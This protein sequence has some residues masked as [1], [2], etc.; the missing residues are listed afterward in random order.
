M[1]SCALEKNSNLSPHTRSRSATATTLQSLWVELIGVI[2]ALM[3]GHDGAQ[4]DYRDGVTVYN[5]R[6]RIQDKSI[7]SPLFFFIRQWMSL[8]G[9]WFC[10]TINRPYYHG[11]DEEL[12]SRACLVNEGAAAGINKTPALRRS[13]RD[14]HTFDINT[15]DSTPWVPIIQPLP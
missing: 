15:F 3:R 11:C 4:C 9:D 8:C 6:L 13:S 1:D 7:Q 10:S 5:I 2:V 12:S 14:T